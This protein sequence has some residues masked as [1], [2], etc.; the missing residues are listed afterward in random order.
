MSQMVNAQESAKKDSTRKTKHDIFISYR[1]KVD[2]RPIGRHLAR[3]VKQALESEGYSV[4]L[5]VED[6]SSK[7]KH[8]EELER[9]RII[10]VLLTDYSFAKGGEN[11]REEI[12]KALHLIETKQINPD[13]V[14]WIRLDGF[15]DDPDPLFQQVKSQYHFIDMPT[16]TGFTANLANAIGIKSHRTL[17][18]YKRTCRIL[19]AVAAVIFMALAVAVL[20]GRKYNNELKQYNNELKQ[21]KEPCIVFA[22]GGTVKNYLKDSCNYDV[23]NQK[24]N[25]FIHMPSK[26]AWT[27]IWDDLNTGSNRLFFPVVLSATQ[28][29]DT[30]INSIPKDFW[31]K[32]RLIEFP[33]G[34]IPLMVQ[35]IP[36]DTSK[37]IITIQEL[38]KYIGNS[39]Y[40]VYTTSP[41]SGT[42]L[43]YA[44]KGVNISKCTLTYN[45]SHF[46]GKW[47]PEN[48]QIFLANT[49]FYYL[50]EKE[51]TQ[52]LMTLV[53]TDSTPIMMPLY[54]YTLASFDSDSYKI[55]VNVQ[56]VLDELGAATVDTAITR[57]KHYTIQLKRK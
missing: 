50:R 26:S 6:S 3:S 9:S 1:C 27:L 34:E 7:Q 47:N 20:F 49:E 19:A 42:Y 4:Y 32:Y 12:Q 51:P 15:T 52:H 55:A 5:D 43:T 10:L 14:K 11:F 30:I 46:E 48:I 54:I 45:E 24:P 35:Q 23:S 40:T 44:K 37:T 25:L 53:D 13:N 39:S 57:D 22:G 31:D 41:T 38:N 36:A 8:L 21:Y 16:G 28:I 56:N 29:S 18:T 2:N 33:V 17:E